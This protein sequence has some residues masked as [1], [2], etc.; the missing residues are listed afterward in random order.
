MARRR[1]PLRIGMLFVLI[2]AIGFVINYFIVLERAH[3]IGVRYTDLQ[4]QW[5]A[6]ASKAKEAK[7]RQ[8]Q[9]NNEIA[10]SDAM[11]KSVDSRLLWAPV[12]GEIL[13]TVPRSVQLTHLGAAA[14]EDEKSINGMIEITGISSAMEPR[15]EAEK[16]RIA[17]DS[18]LSAKFKHV[19]S[20]F[21]NLDD[22]DQYVMLDGRRMPTASFTMEF[23]I[24][25]RDPIVVAP[26]PPERK[27]KE[28]A[29]TE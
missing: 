2:V 3:I 8:D 17:L 29:A 7:A 10:A 5:T 25:V 19:T 26:P 24:Q 23:Q 20:V 12:L 21:K 13:Q 28:A 11:I 16:L 9:L 1:D 18:K 15:K 14:P 4:G 22:S 27:P 6:I